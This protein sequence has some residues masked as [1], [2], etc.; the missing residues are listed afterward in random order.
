MRWFFSKAKAKAAEKKR[1]PDAERLQ[2]EDAAYET[3]KMTGGT[4]IAGTVP[5]DERPDRFNNLQVNKQ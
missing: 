4:A 1:K 3:L 5:F 2:R